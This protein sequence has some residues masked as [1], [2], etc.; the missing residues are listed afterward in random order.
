[1]INLAEDREGWEI[2]N[3]NLATIFDYIEYTRNIWDN[4]SFSSF[5][6][7]LKNSTDSI[8]CDY[9]SMIFFVLT[10]GSDDMFFLDKSGNGIPF[11]KFVEEIKHCTDQYS[12]NI[13]KIFY[14][15]ACR[16]KSKFSFFKLKKQAQL[17]FIE[18][19]FAVK[20]KNLSGK[21]FV[22]KKNSDEFNDIKKKVQIL[23]HSNFMR[24]VKVTFCQNNYCFFL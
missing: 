5:K 10:H 3:T 11:E 19:N 17:N 12:K 1:M 22:L 7:L 15:G 16:G 4:E 23:L 20:M 13:P 6:A 18:H 24:Q 2:D 14:F 9:K 21:S 8:K